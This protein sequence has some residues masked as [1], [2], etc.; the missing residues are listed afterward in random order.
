MQKL[1]VLLVGTTLAITASSFA[2][3]KNFSKRSVTDK[4]FHLGNNDNKDW[5]KFT[6]AKPHHRDELELSFDAKSSSGDAVMKIRS[7]DVK[8][9]FDVL[10]NGKKIGRL[11]KGKNGKG[12]TTQYFE[13]PKGLLKSGSNKFLLRRDEKSSDD[14]WVGPIRIEYRSLESALALLKLRVRVV[15]TNGKPLPSR[16]TLT[17]HA[18]GDDEELVEF[19]IPKDDRWAVR[20]GVAYSLDGSLDVALESGKYTVYATRGFEYGLGRA[21]VELSGESAEE[22]RITLEREVDTTG[23]LAGD[24]HIHTLTHS[25]HGDA[26]V[27]ERVVTIAGEGVEIAIATDHNHHTDYRPTEKKVGVE[28]HYRS[29][30]GNEFT[31]KL[32]HFNAFPIEKKVKPAKHNHKTWVQLIRALRKTP[33]VRVVICNHPRRKSFAKG[34]WGS[35]GVH[36]IS[37]ELEDG[38]DWLGVDA[39]EVLNGKGLLKT[40]ALNFQDW[41]RLLNRG[42][43]LTAVA[44][45]DS[46]T[47]DQPV[48]QCRTYVRS[49]TDDP[50]RIDVAEVVDNVLE[51]R[52]AVSMGLLADVRVAEKFGIGD[53]AV[54]LEEDVAVEIKVSAP[55][56]I[57]A[58]NV[59]LYLN[60]RKLRESKIEHSP[61]AV[62]KFHETWTIG[63]PHHDAHLVVIASGP[64]VEG[65]FWS[66]QED[67]RYVIGGTNP[68]WLDGDGDGLFTS[69]RGY[70]E[71]LVEKHG[72][73][74]PELR[75]AL[76]E[77]D[78]AVAIQAAS[79]VRAKLQFALQSVY[80][81]LQ[82][83]ANEQLRTLLSEGGDGG[84][85]TDAK[86]YAEYLESLPEI[87]VVTRREKRE[88]E[89]PKTGKKKKKRTAK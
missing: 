62:V 30:I 25:G 31:T 4:V 78:E 88:A 34:P 89:P 19:E 81:K 12:E 14:I 56:W 2:A 1:T 52:V 67:D 77:C 48:G 51:G 46:H 39:V 53:L 83:R 76:R 33:G 50:D 36:P 57:A 69:A 27:K 15:D 5:A 10:L 38:S 29:I 35:M 60:G 43:R 79:V 72:T 61:D 13:I 54:D 68:I 82:S 63:R 11:K 55:R 74:S 28:G 22:V 49:E 64:P 71:A 59:A 20:E 3:P 66:Y 41:F 84:G 47:V 24:T 7:G 45:S 86:L 65:K 32:G 37:A 70:A 80:E 75:E 23:W 58:T 73:E 44:G 26:S 8:S 42:H 6:T 16:I 85:R 9:K 40:P 18:R 21:E 87:D 17:K